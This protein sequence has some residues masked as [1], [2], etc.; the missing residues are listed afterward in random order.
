[1]TW[2]DTVKI[3]IATLGISLPLIYIASVVGTVFEQL[4]YKYNKMIDEQREMLKLQK[5]WFEK[6]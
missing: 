3:L 1:M 6:Q 2:D 4:M 5:A